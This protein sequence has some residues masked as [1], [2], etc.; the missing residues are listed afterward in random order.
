MTSQCGRSPAFFSP[1]RS[2]KKHCN[3]I[4]C[5]NLDRKSSALCPAV[6]CHTAKPTMTSIDTGFT[7]PFLSTLSIQ[8]STFTSWLDSEK[9]RIDSIAEQ[10]SNLHGEKQRRIKGL[11]RRLDEVRCQRGLVNGDGDV[12]V[13]GVAQQKRALEEKQRKLVADAKVLRDKNRAAQMELD[14]LLAEQSHQQTLAEATRSKK[15]QLAEM[16]NTTVEDLTKGLLNYK[17]VGLGFERVGVEGDLL[18]KFTRLDPTDLLR[19]FSFILT[20]RQNYELSSCD[21][22]LDKKKTDELLSI[23]NSDAD[24]GFMYFLVGMRKLF[25]ETLS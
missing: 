4:P 11:L 8:R 18:F 22:P 25:K 9:S 1:L 6:I 15:V 13:G 7:A 2:R 16:K 12:S 23:L 17:Y 3:T 5:L 20:L 14:E 24:N 21:P 19:P 10:I